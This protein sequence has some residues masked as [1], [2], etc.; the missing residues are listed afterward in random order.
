MP[1]IDEIKDIWEMVKQSLKTQMPESAVNLWFGDLK[2]VSFENNTV[3]FSITSEFKYNTIINQKYSDIIGAQF[4]RLVGFPV[5]IEIEFVGTPASN[6]PILAMLREESE[7]RAAQSTP[8]TEKEEKEEPPKPTE[9]KVGG[10]MPPYNFEYTFDNFIVGESNKFAHAACI[11]VANNPAKDYNPLF[12]YGPSGLGKTHL[13]YAI[14]NKIKK[15]K[16]DAEIIYIKGEDFTNQMIEC[17]SRQAMPEFRQK[18]R[19][20]D[21]LLIDD[22]QFIAGKDSTQ[23]EFFHTFNSLYEEHKQI[24]LTSDRPPR[25][26]K[27][28]EDRLKTRFEWGLIADI[29]PPEHELRV[30]IIQKKAEQVKIKMPG[31]VLNFLAINLRSNIRQMEGAIKKLA[32]L[33]FL[34]GKEITLETA[35]SCI[36]ELLEGAE[37]TNVTV[38]KIF[39][40]I[41]KKY[42][43]TKEDIL[44]K[45]RNKEIAL[46]RHVAIYLIRRITDMSFPNIGK[47]IG[48]DHST[49]INSVELMSNKY[50]TDSLF[51]MEIEELKKEVTGFTIGDEYADMPMPK[52]EII[53]K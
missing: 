1:Y 18:Y 26:I 8:Y 27:T 40:A 49:V 45:K 47:L 30:A 48:R 9:P 12:I 42:G 19:S 6:E 29:A 2:I 4:S 46:P 34:S 50:L 16:P 31:E 20:C 21:V 41:Y 7:R 53:K 13:L 24:I 22:I 52:I 35:K 38:D 33:S 10:T 3:R 44:S 36:A 5:S 32:A 28:L 51:K 15:D 23:Q 39:A 17:L 14:T 25:E 43:V 37:P 11:A